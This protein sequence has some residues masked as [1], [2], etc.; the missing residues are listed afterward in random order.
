MKTVRHGPRCALACAAA[1]LLC[2]CGGGDGG[3]VCGTVTYRGKALNT[4]EVTFVAEGKSRSAVIGPDGTY[5]LNDV[6]PGAHRVS[7]LVRAPQPAAA[8]AARKGAPPMP[9]ARARPVVVPA[10]Y[11]SPASSG[12]N[13]R[14]EP[15]RQTID[16]PL[17][18]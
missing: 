14:V 18:D 6:P 4:G 8:T 9:G 2:G 3:T 5:S 12:L 15:G 17:K 1:L 10:K 13:F 7:V 16:I 11:A